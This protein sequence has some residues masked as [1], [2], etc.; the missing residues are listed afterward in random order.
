MK[1]D[2]F[3]I[4]LIL[5]ILSKL[6]FA[7]T[8]STR[9]GTRP[10]LSVRAARFIDFSI[11]QRERSR[12]LA[13]GSVTEDAR[14]ADGPTSDRQGRPPNVLGWLSFI[15]LFMTGVIGL[16]GAIR[17]PPDLAGAAYLLTGGLA[18]GAVVLLVLRRVP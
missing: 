5:S 7:N 8:N 4:M 14:M 15:G 3:Q 6:A 17:R 9:A 13:D 11:A 2:Q 1:T 16:S 18:F 12:R 10:Q